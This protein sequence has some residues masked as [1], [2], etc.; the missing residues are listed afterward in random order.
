MTIE[1]EPPVEPEVAQ[2]IEVPESDTPIQH[3]PNLT[4]L[5][6]IEVEPGI[7]LDSYENRDILRENKLSWEPIYDANGNISG[8]IEARSNEMSRQ[9]GIDMLNYRRA[10]LSNP[11][12]YNSDYLTDLDLL[13]ISDLDKFV[14]PWVKALTREWMDLQEKRANAEPGESGL[15]PIYISP[16]SRCTYM[17]VDGVR[18][19]FWHRGRASDGGLCTT[20]RK[21]KGNTA[22]AAHARAKEVL[23]QSSYL[24]AEALVNLS[25]KA[26]SEPVRLKASTEIL[27]RVGIRAGFEID[28]NIQ[29]EVKPAAEILMDRFEQ[30]RKGA[31]DLKQILPGSDTSDA[32]IEVQDAEEVIE[33]EVDDDA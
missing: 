3:R 27:D 12:D 22:E 9:R 16:P 2:P 21:S 20:H 17:K 18:C 26:A 25:Q 14:P 31:E 28:A 23:K 7:C 5:G 13:L 8:V 32:T 6:I 11:N 29:L 1:I 10:I 19:L 33:A 4:A 15:K 24:A 30:L